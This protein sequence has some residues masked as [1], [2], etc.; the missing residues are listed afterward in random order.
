MPWQDY[1]RSLRGHY[2]TLAPWARH[3]LFP[4]KAPPSVPWATTVSDPRVGDVRLTGLLGARPDAKSLLLVVHGLGGAV[5]NFYAVSAA[6]AAHAAG[7]QCLR[8]SLRG[9][10]RRGEDF[11][12]AGLTADIEAAIASRELANVARIYVVGYSL[13]GHVTLRYAALGADP[14]VRAVAAVCPPLDLDASARAL[15]APE[16]LVYRVHILR[17]LQEIY[18]EVAA[19]RRVPI[20][21][22]Q[23]R[24]IRTIR[25][26]DARTVAPRH[27]FRDAEDYYARVS[28]API[29]TRLSVP[30]LLVFAESDPLVPDFVVRPALPRRSAG[31]DVR[32]IGRG[33]H[34]GFPAD[35]DLGLAAPLGLE[36]QIVA[37]LLRHES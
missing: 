23:A 37:W 16:R 34:V 1:R 24:K 21:V 4:R 3:L 15:D 32:W 28:V 14:R 19:R 18:G 35:L 25:E 26:W 17:G 6:R 22:D 29:L 27:G 36:H 7:I 2:W 5:E 9:S 12:H 10:D 8:L 20:T 11:Y 31:L 30:A 33:G 13:G